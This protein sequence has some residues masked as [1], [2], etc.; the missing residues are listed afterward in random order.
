MIKKFDPAFDPPCY[1]TIKKDIGSSYQASFQAI[2]EMIIQTCETAAIT[3]DLWTS[4]AK[5]GYIRITCHW[6]TEKMKLIDILICVESINYPHTGNNIRQ[7][8]ITKLELLGLENKVK[9][10]VTDN[11][12]NMVKAIREWDDVD[13][14]P[15]SAHTLQL[16]VIKGLEKAKSFTKR[17]KKLIE[18][19]NSPKQNERLEEAQRELIA[20][21]QEQRADDTD[22]NN[23]TNLTQPNIQQEEL[24][25]QQGSL[26]ILRT[27]N[28]VKTRWG[29][30]LASW[31]RLQELKNPIKRVILNLSLEDGNEAKKDY[32]KLVIRNLKDYE[33]DFL[34]KLIEVFKPIEEAT[35]WLGGQK[36]CTLSLMY[37]VIHAL[38]YD[39]IP[40]INDDEI[41]N[42]ESKY[43]KFLKF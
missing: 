13:H 18:F 25:I 37:P 7:T 6:L 26:R 1:A 11:G 30:S 22:N 20:R 34:N 24:G 16:C 36:Y 39:Y 15:C 3:T 28:D 42:K 23:S 9:A 35:E 4:H 14:I 32:N 2:K 17:F 12:S 31:K 21:Y 27:I 43:F 29:S 33:W 5:S 41:I 8:I 40:I 10:A 19:F 38:K